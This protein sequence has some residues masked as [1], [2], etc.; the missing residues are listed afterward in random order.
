[1]AN[2][3]QSTGLPHRLV[4]YRTSRVVDWELG[5]RQPLLVACRRCEHVWPILW[6]RCDASLINKATPKCCPWCGNTKSKEICIASRGPG[7]LDRYAV[8]LAAELQRARE[9]AA[10]PPIEFS[11]TV[12]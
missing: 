1:M 8:W 5:P 12:T 3:N 4:D 11:D 6:M 10:T 2:L 7:D 9:D